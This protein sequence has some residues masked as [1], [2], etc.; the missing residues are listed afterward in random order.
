MNR[1]PDLNEPLEIEISEAEILADLLYPAGTYPAGAPAPVPD[2]RDQ[3]PG[4]G[5]SADRGSGRTRTPRREP[6]RHRDRA[7]A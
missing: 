6:A 4:D 2:I 5:G 3:G 7:A 1:F